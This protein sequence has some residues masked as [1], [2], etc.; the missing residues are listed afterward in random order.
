[1]SADASQPLH[2]PEL[3]MFATLLAAGKTEAKAYQES[4][5]GVALACGLS[6]LLSPATRAR[7]AWL[8]QHAP[9]TGDPAYNADTLARGDIIRMLLGA[10]LNARTAGNAMAEV[11]AVELLGKT[12]GVFEERVSVEGEVRHRVIIVPAKAP[13][14]DAPFHEVRPDTRAL[15]LTRGHSGRRDN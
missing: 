14:I 9:V 12:I 4:S 6:S 15:A 13:A 10:R 7:V 3:E 2:P 11:K 5:A 8:K 1:M